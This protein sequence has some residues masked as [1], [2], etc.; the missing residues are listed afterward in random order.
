MAKTFENASA[1]AK[2][3]TINELLRKGRTQ[4]TK[5]V[6]KV[7][8][9]PAAE[10]KKS[11]TLTFAKNRNPQ[12]FIRIR[13]RRLPLD[14]FAPRPR[15][16]QTRRGVRRGVSV[17]IKKSEGRKLVK[18]GFVGKFRS[19][20]SV[21]TRTDKAIREKKRFPIQRK[22]TLSPAKMFTLEAEK[23]LFQLIEKEMPEIFDRNLRH[24]IRR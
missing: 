9:I 23:S 8:N 21:Y 11:F 24:F 12:G 16:I 10:L 20:V 4:S 15:K 14:L 2:R 19:S 17:R 6:R 18:G 5:Q 22:Y 13:A 3:R 7:Y 1:N